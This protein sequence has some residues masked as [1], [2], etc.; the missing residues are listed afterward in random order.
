MITR[1]MIMWS[2]IWSG[3]WSNTWPTHIIFKKQT[4]L[5][6]LLLDLSLATHHPSSK[7][8]IDPTFVAS[9]RRHWLATPVVRRGHHQLVDRHNKTSMNI[10]IIFIDAIYKEFYECWLKRDTY[11]KTPSQTYKS[12][13]KPLAC[14]STYSSANAFPIRWLSERSSRSPEE[15]WV[16]SQEN[17]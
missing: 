17:G 12:L 7:T 9:R 11:N 3:P 10:A 14:V 13:I 1:P 2:N 16:K 8:S 5:M 4:K 15:P 6:L